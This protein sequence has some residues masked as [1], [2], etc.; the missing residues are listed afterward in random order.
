M[1]EEMGWYDAQSAIKAI[2]ELAR[3]EFLKL[4]ET[5]WSYF[6]DQDWQKYFERKHISKGLPLSPISEEQ[7]L[8]IMD[9]FSLT[10]FESYELPDTEWD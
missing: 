9:E 3:D 1:E 10:A 5:A 2:D 8:E 7:A 4:K 6:G